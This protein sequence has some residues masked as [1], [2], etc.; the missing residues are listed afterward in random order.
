[1]GFLCSI[2]LRQGRAPPAEVPYAR[3]AAGAA[4]EILQLLDPDNPAPCW[5]VPIASLSSRQQ[6]SVARLL[7]AIVLRRARMRG[8]LK[9]VMAALE[10]ALA[11]DLVDGVAPIQAVALL[12]RS[13][14]LKPSFV[15]RRAK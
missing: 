7:L 10:V 11:F 1:M 15:M 9:K 5:R 6:D 12:R 14:A 4:A 3:L 13:H 8:D 2:A